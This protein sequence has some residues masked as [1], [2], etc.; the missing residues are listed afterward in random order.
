M[1]LP[2]DQYGTSYKLPPWIES[3]IQVQGATYRLTEEQKA[4]IRQ[5]VMADILA[6]YAKGFSLHTASLKTYLTSVAR[7]A[8][9]NWLRKERYT[10]HCDSLARWT[11]RAQAIEDA[12]AKAAGRPSVPLSFPKHREK[13]VPRRYEQPNT[14]FEGDGEDLAL[15]APPRALDASLD[16][17][18]TLLAIRQ[19]FASGGLTASE[20]RV[21]SLAGSGLTNEEIAQR[22]G[23]TVGAANKRHERAARS[24]RHR[25]GTVP[26]VPLALVRPPA[27]SGHA[28][29]GAKPERTDTGGRG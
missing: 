9:I 8:T 25:L 21:L 26:S 29:D 23:L 6:T 7:N 28:A 24:L 12:T 5:E 22:L 13:I 19:V 11:G 17:R 27:C 4:D 10:F 16:V 3:I 14:I 20:S 15:K 18:E 2:L 1:P